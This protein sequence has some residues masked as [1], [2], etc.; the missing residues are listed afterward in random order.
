MALIQDVIIGIDV[1]GTF[2][3][4]YCEAGQQT[5][6]V[7]TPSTP[8][9]PGGDVVEGIRL[10]AARLGLPG[11]QEL[12]ARTSLILHGSTVATNTLLTRSGA[13]V[14]VI[15]T[16]GFRDIVEMRGG[17]RESTFDPHQ[18]KVPPIS[19]RHLRY[20]VDEATD[21]A[22]VLVASPT[23]ED[24]EN[25]IGELRRQGANA[26]AICFKHA[27][28]NPTN[29]QVASLVVEEAWP[30]AFA[31]RS[32]EVASRARLYDRVSTAAVNSYVGPKA[33]EYVEGL[34][35]RLNDLGFRGQLLVMG[36]NGGVMAPSDAARFPV[37]LLLS[38]PSAGPG[39]AALTLR[40]QNR[41]LHAVIIDMGGTSFDVSVMRDGRVDVSSNRDLNGYRVSVPMLEISTVGAGGG[42]IAWVD[43]IGLLRVGPQSAGASP[44]P[45]AY[46]LGGSEPTVTDANLVLGLLAPDALLG[47]V[48][49]LSVDHAS[50]AVRSRIAVPLGVSVEDAAR[51]IHWVATAY[52][53]VAVREMTVGKGIDPRSFPLVLA[54][55]AGGL[56]GAEI[57]KGLGIREVI[58]PRNAGV[59][60]ALGMAYSEARYDRNISLVR[61]WKDVDRRQLVTQI[62]TAKSEALAPL[63]R[64]GDDPM[65]VRFDFTVEA[66]YAGQFHELSFQINEGGLVEDDPL[67]L[68]SLFHRVHASAYGF[69]IDSAE[70]EVVNIRVTAISAMRRQAQS[71]DDGSWGVLQK[72]V[73]RIQLDQHSEEYAIWQLGDSHNAQA[74]EVDGPSLIE[75]DTSTLLVP[76]GWSGRVWPTGDVSLISLTDTPEAEGTERSNVDIGP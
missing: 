21:R 69:S 60:C 66:R 52:M 57:A 11:E 13:N 38:G 47:G 14:G 45:A 62:E 70:V 4:V 3:D 6:V 53:T 25:A 30:E 72:G 16:R 29:E 19:P 5:S 2:T 20:E 49:R 76:S 28:A 43:E 18:P 40:A 55:G 17:V 67:E 71:D 8:D 44:G 37:N 31:T 36:S 65:P 68:E 59:L 32:T 48:R 41:S 61:S 75:L 1:G 74:N 54:G 46:A 35:R 50:H 22:G 58:V 10:A 33:R 64:V 51:G 9:D 26:V 56:H 12:L 27:W 73:R 24:L 34:Q 42:S 63:S 39:G 7:K 23:R 15:T